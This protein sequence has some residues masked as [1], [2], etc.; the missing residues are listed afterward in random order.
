MFSIL[1]RTW[2]CIKKR[3]TV[4]CNWA[5]TSDWLVSKQNQF[6]LCSEPAWLPF[7]LVLWYYVNGVFS[8]HYLSVVIQIRTNG[9]HRLPLVKRW[10]K[11]VYAGR[12]IPTQTLSKGLI[13]LPFM[14][15]NNLGACFHH[16]FFFIQQFYSHVS[17]KWCHCFNR[18]SEVNFV[19]VW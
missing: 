5:S 18:L 11:P 2:K 7:S 14:S 9:V 8:T 15:K 3:H 16:F 17:Q 4:N 12:L 10:E 13:F 19:P 6:P 1:F